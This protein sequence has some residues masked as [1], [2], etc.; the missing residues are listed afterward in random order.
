MKDKI[1]VFDHACLDEAEEKETTG[2]KSASAMGLDALI[3]EW[4]E[5]AEHWYK[6]SDETKDKFRKEEYSGFADTFDCC[7]DRLEEVIEGS[8]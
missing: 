4:R 7:A 6:E 2:N 5:L 8:I 3:K 1:C